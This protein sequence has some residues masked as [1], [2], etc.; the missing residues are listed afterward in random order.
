MAMMVCVFSLN[1]SSNRNFFGL[2][3]VPS[4]NRLTNCQSSGK[5]EFLTM[6]GCI[7]PALMFIMATIVAFTNKSAN[8]DPTKGS[9]RT[10]KWRRAREDRF[11]KEQEPGR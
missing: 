6:C 1:C 5:M 4:G 7:A 10:T 11:K 8:D 3:K 9:S 2:E